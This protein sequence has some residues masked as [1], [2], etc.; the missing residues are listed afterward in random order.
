MLLRWGR[1]A[2][3]IFARSNELWT[4]TP[5]MQVFCLKYFAQISLEMFAFLFE[6][7]IPLKSV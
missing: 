6:V 7:V 3:Q 2:A 1:A 4:L 5:A